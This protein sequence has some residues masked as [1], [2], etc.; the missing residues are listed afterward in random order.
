MPETARDLR[1]LRPIE[2]IVLQGTP[3]CNLDCAYCDLS[4][5]SRR[6][7]HTMP[8]ELV[9]TAF[10]RIFES[11]RCAGRVEVI[12]HSGEP[13]TL[14][15]DYYDA[16]IDRILACRD[17][18]ARD[19]VE[20]GFDIQTNGVL[21]DAGWQAFF[22]RHRHHLSVGISCDGPARMHDRYRRNWSG[23]ASHDR[24][25]RGMRLLSEIGIRF[26]VIA[27]VTDDTLAD[28]EGFL[29][30]FWD[31]RG[32]LSGFHFNVLASGDAA[33]PG[34]PG[35]CEHD[36]DRYYGF[37]RTLIRLLRERRAA[38]TGFAVQNFTQALGRILAPPGAAP[39]CVE[40]TAPLKSLNLDA[41]GTVTTFYA[42]LAPEAFAD[43]YGDGRG[44]ALG[45]LGEAPLE[46]LLASEKL[47]RMLDDFAASD[48]ACAA[49]CA[50]HSL[51]SGGFELTKLA[52]HGRFDADE[53]PECVVHVKALM[54]A[55]LDDAAA[56]RTV[57][58]G[59][60]A[61]AGEARP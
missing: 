36:R 20:L 21:I 2:L 43:Q 56:E 17:A 60:P 54:D 44:F 13:L 5:E 53:T 51:C 25:L 35:Y 9:E 31:W 40:S 12:W 11:G 39:H 24:T 30:F 27:V 6:M 46:T 1:P 48:A 16:A 49:A 52:R 37:Y 55:V 18:H 42:G 7:R 32:A 33:G 50:Y 38:E 14:R 57:A 47:G 26:K 8:L 45:N 59:A 34:G 61:P 22:D 15:P 29:D 41:H 23:R 19:A 4:A 3:F 58:D 10:R 28:P